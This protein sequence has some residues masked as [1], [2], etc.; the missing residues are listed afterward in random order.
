MN[1]IVGKILIGAVIS[2]VLIVMF[3]RRTRNQN[4]KNT[5]DN[6][7]TGKSEGEIGYLRSVLKRGSN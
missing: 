3:D 4:N 7:L 6:D 2:G 5:A 1:W